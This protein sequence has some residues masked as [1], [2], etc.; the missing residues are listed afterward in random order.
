M[1]KTILFIA[2]TICLALTACNNVNEQSVA[3][4][5]QEQID[6]TFTVESFV[7]E[8]NKDIPMQIDKATTCTAVRTEGKYIVYDY[9]IDENVMGAPLCDAPQEYWFEIRTITL[10]RCNA[11]GFTEVGDEI[12]TFYN[13]A[14]DEGYTIVHRFIGNISGCTHDIIFSPEELLSCMNQANL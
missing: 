12:K 6:N 9:M 2:A 11:F 3:N 7:N 8:M 10:A 13:Q 5:D 4:G 14:K 1:K